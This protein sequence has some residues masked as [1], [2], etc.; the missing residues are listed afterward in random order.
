M[1]HKER[2]GRMKGKN[3]M[4]RMLS[5]VDRLLVLYIVALLVYEM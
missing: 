5:I 3:D 1:A 4:G 2:K